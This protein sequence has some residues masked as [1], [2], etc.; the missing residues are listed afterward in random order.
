MKYRKQTT[1]V[2]IFDLYYWFYSILSVMVDYKYLKMYYFDLFPVFQWEW[3]VFL[4]WHKK[5]SNVGV[6]DRES[7]STKK[8]LHFI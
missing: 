4:T 7:N 1:S 5:S 3:A 2:S 6:E 8:K